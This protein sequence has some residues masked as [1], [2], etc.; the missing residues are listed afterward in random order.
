TFTPLVDTDLT[1]NPLVLEDLNN[2][3]QLETIAIGLDYNHNLAYVNA[4]QPDGQQA[5]GF[6]I[7]VQDQNS[8]KSWRNHVRILV[9]DFDGDGSKEV[10]V[11]E[12]LTSTT[13]ALRLFGHDGTP[14]TFNSP[15]LTGLPF[16]MAAADLDHNGK[17]E[18]ILANYNGSQATL[19]V[20]LPD[21]SERPGWPVD[22]SSSNGNLSILASI[23]VGDFNRDGHEEIAFSREAG[24]YLFNS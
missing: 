17:L 5:P 24:I 1:I 16:A 7:Q 12:G 11:Q 20:F 15:V 18:T 10:L 19:H 23:A 13:Y 9:G 8:L 6:P 14:K 4:W 21:G 2:N 22:V 3:F